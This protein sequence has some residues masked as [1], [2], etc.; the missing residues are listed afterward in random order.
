MDIMDKIND[1]VELI[2]KNSDLMDDFKKDPVKVIKSL[3]GK[4]DLDK[5]LLDNL[6]ADDD[7][8]DKVVTAVKGKIT[9]DKAADLLG[10]LKKLF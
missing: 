4:L 1:L 6:K 7:M 9:A 5:A 10:G 8:M 3:L 2:T